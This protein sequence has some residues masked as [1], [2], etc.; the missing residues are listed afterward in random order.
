MKAWEPKISF[1]KH[2]CKCISLIENVVHT[3][4]LKASEFSAQYDLVGPFE[5]NLSISWDQYMKKYKVNI[6]TGC[7]FS[8]ITSV[9]GIRL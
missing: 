7:S 3:E 1:T 4:I 6:L 5:I 9:S 2:K 8:S